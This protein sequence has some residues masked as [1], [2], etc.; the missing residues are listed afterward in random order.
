VSTISRAYT[1]DAAVEKPAIKLSEELGWNHVNAYHEKLGMDGTLGRET[2]SEIFLRQRLRNAFERLNPDAPVQAIDQA[3]DEL[4]KDRS[5]LHYAR[6]NREVHE[7]LRDRVP[8]SIRKPDGS[9]QTERLVVI[10]WDNPSNNDFLLVSQLWIKSDLYERRTDLLGFV[11]GIPLVFIELKAAHRNLKRAYD[12]NL[13]D[14][15]DTIPNVFVPNG[16]IVLSNGAET[17]VGTITSPWEYFLEWKKINSEGEEG[18]VS[19]ETVFRGMCTPERL[20]DIV[21]NFTLFQELPG[22]LVKLVARNHQ[23]LG[24]NNALA[25]LQELR[26]G[27]EEPAASPAKLGVFWHTQGSGKTVSMIFFTQKVLRTMPGNWT[28]VVVTDRDDLDD[29]AYKEF[30]AAGVVEEHTRATS[31]RHLRT[32]LCEDRRYVF[33]LIQK[34]RTEHG[35][36]HPVLSD[37]EDVIVITDEAHRT[38]YDVLALNMRNALPNA[39]FIGFTGTPLIAGEEKTKEVFGDYVSIYN[40]ASSTADGATVPLYFENRIPTLKLTNPRFDE[41]LTDIVEGADLDPEQERKLA[42]L[43]GQQYEL[44][45]REDRLDRVGKDIVN[46]FL[47]RGFPGKAM[48]VSIDKATAVRTYLKVQAAWEARLKRNEARLASAKLTADERDLL[49]QETAFMRSSDMAVVISQSQNE[50]AEMAER[51]IDIKPIRKRIVEEDLEGR[52]KDAQDPLRIAFVCSM[53]TTGFDVPS[54]STIYLDKPMRNQALMQTITRANRVFPGKN[55]GL[56]VGYVDILS[57]LHKALGLYAS[58]GALGQ[59]LLPVEEKDAL[60]DALRDAVHEIRRFCQAR[61]VDLDHITTLR[62]F[63]WVEALKDVSDQL[64]LSDEE[65]SSF[66]ERATRVERLFKAI[67]PDDRANEFAPIRKVIRVVMDRIGETGGRPEVSGVMAQIEQL[68]DESVAANAYL[69][70]SEERKSLM[71]LS[72][73]DWD[74]VKAM[75]ASG[76]QRTAAQKLRSMLTA[77]I[78]NLTRLNPTRVDLYERFQR[79]LDQYNAGSLNVEQYFDELVKLSRSLTEEEARAVSAGLTE[80]QLAI[81]DLLTRPGPDLTSDE[82]AQVKR[83]AEEVLAVLKREKLVLDWRKEQRTRAGVRVTVEETL[84]RLPEK[85]TRQIYAQKCDAVYQHVFESYFDDGHSVYDRVAASA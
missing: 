17:K 10:D 35:E 13:T 52:F 53:W 8:V 84:D 64:M 48:V 71:D 36:R 9:K 20:L 60:V 62:Q 57:N 3:I 33:T 11:N 22:G 34:F 82:E 15:R 74:N 61:D 7:L 19:I 29:Q 72:E 24:V 75:F 42:R 14:Y 26:R 49:E 67:L 80:E 81:F 55:N 73:V 79:L 18:R 28:F 51:G 78:T 6:A 40:Y 16:F 37:R 54:C 12:D 50:V 46:H 1:E 77:R 65:T 32:L 66:L 85:Y 69:I 63:E 38:Q 70:G 47:G 27:A 44:I 4:T 76:R 30:S 59:T 56:I 45:T 2:R 43:L 21:G 68:L 31:T 23:Y 41:D 58:T 25:R 5:A 83:V 39:G